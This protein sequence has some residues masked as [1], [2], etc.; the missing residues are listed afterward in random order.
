MHKYCVLIHECL[1]TRV[2]IGLPVV[3]PLAGP[4]AEPL[5]IHGYA[6]G[7][8]ESVLGGGGLNGED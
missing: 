2:F 5:L 7:L 4:L 3:E 1:L 8:S 6:C